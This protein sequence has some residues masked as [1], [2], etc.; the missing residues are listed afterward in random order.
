MQKQTISKRPWLLTCQQHQA[1]EPNSAYAQDIK[2]TS[3]GSCLLMHDN[4]DK[5][6]L[7]ISQQ[8]TT[9][10][11]RSWFRGEKSHK[12]ESVHVNCELIDYIKFYS[13][14]NRKCSRSTIAFRN[15]YDVIRM[16]DLKSFE[17]FDFF[18]IIVKWW[19][20]SCSMMFF[21]TFWWYC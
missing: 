17:S 7:L 21:K 14:L 10:A 4:K 6:T 15:H 18:F 16:N 13:K 11:L 5:L 3:S 8:S 1:F 19:S 2:T 9:G 20:P 12:V